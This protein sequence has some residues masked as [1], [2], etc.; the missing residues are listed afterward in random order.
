MAES[1]SLEAFLEIFMTLYEILKT[2]WSFIITIFNQLKPLFQLLLM[3]IGSLSYMLSIVIYSVGLIQGLI[4]GSFNYLFSSFEGFLKKTFELL[5]APLIFIN[6]FI[7]FM[8]ISISYILAT[9]GYIMGIVNVTKN[10]DEILF[11]S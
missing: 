6:K 8:F 2:L 9:I 11:N 10:E 3:I 7:K 1:S 4:I 5:N